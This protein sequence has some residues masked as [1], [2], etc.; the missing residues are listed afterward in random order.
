MVEKNFAKNGARFAKMGLKIFDTRALEHPRPLEIMSEALKFAHLGEILLMIHRRE[1]LPLYDIIRAQGL[2]FRVFESDFCGEF[3]QAAAPFTVAEGF[4]IELAL[5]A[6]DSNEVNFSRNFQIKSKKAGK[7]EEPKV[8]I[9]I[10][11]AEVLADRRNLN[12]TLE[13]FESVFHFRPKKTSKKR[14]LC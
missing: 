7:N 5:I 2:E 6:E 10:A 3:A 1:P 4:P 9:I 11:C 12:S 8:C 14:G 13:I